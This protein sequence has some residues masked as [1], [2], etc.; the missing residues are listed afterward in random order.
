MDEEKRYDLIV[1]GAGPGGYEAAFEAARLGMTVALIEKEA[2]GGTCLNHGCIPTKSL[3][4]ASDLYD[5]MKRADRFGVHADH[6]TYD[7]KEMKERKDEVVRTLRDGIASQAKQKNV[8]VFPGEGVI[9]DPHTVCVG[10]EEVEARFILIAT[11]SRAA[12][13]PIPGTDLPGVVTSDGMLERTEPCRRLVI[14]GGG[15]IGMEFASLYSKLGTEVTVIEALPRILANMDREISQSLKMQMKKR[16]VRILVSARVEGIRKEGA[17]LVVAFSEKDVQAELN[18]DCI[19]VAVGR[20]PSTDGLFGN[21][22]EIPAME[23]GRILTD[24]VGRTSV[25]SIYAC[26]DVTGGVMLAHVATAEG[27]NAVAHMKWVIEKEAGNTDVSEN[28]L[29]KRLIDLSCVPSCI[30]TTP[31]IASV[32][33]TTDQAKE[34]GIGAESRKVVMS[35]NGRTVIADGDRGFIRIV[36]AKEDGRLLGAQLVCERATDLISEFADAIVN[37]LSADDLGRVI[38]PHPSFSEAVTEA[39]RFQTQPV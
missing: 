29:Q 23:R 10:A 1:I 26:G 11:G 16:G 22:A 33:L 25:S 35:A 17:S 34:Q 6:V 7:L 36:F 15:V 13:P 8:T 20:R 2:L 37:G 24:G 31:E 9:E 32:G 14:I 5:E 12:M 28:E 19:L 30:Y 4:H 39:A 38:R 27:R 3:L 21:G 18:A